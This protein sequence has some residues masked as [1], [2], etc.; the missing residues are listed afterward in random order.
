MLSKKLFLFILSLNIFIANARAITYP[1]ITIFKTTTQEDKN[2][3]YSNGNIYLK[4]FQGPGAIEV[5][6]IIGNKITEVNTQDLYSFQF[7]IELESRNMYIIRVV[8][9]N[10]VKTFKIVAS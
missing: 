7:L 5:Y 9:S 8:S 10:E 4:G 6:S 3:F 2:V 1:K